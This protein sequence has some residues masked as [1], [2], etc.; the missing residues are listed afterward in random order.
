MLKHHRLNQA[1]ISTRPDAD[2]VFTRVLDVDHR[3][4]GIFT[5]YSG[6]ALSVDTDIRETLFHLLTY[7]VDAD[8]GNHSHVRSQLG[9]GHSLIRAFTSG[10]YLV[11]LSLNSLPALRRG[12]DLHQV[13]YI[14]A[15]Q[16]G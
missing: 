13:I 4:S 14:D 11:L 16:Y 12:A 7:G 1:S 2:T 10:H 5:G 9:R 3:H 8:T 6:D 15:A